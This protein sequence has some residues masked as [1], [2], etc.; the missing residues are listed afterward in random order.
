MCSC[1]V[2]QCCVPAL[3]ALSALCLCSSPQYLT[4]FLHHSSLHTWPLSLLCC[5]SSSELMCSA[6]F[7]LHSPPV[8]LPVQLPSFLSGSWESPL[9]GIIFS[10]PLFFLIFYP[11]PVSKPIDLKLAHVVIFMS[12][13]ELCTSHLEYLF[14]L[15]CFFYFL[16]FIYSVKR[17]P[18]GDT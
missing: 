10:R 9:G 1:F 16:F 3:F 13:T 15:L 4:G 6:D 18:C 7:M 2:C 11:H 8:C 12:M 14:L 17:T 5:V